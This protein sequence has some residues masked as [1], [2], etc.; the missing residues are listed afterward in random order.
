MRRGS[1]AP[2]NLNAV[3]KSSADPHRHYRAGA[4]AIVFDFFED[5][6]R[7]M[8]NIAGSIS[9]HIYVGDI[10]YVEAEG[11]VVEGDNFHKGGKPG[12]GVVLFDI[13]D[14]PTLGTAVDTVPHIDTVVHL[15]LGKVMPETKIKF[16]AIVIIK[17]MHGVLERVR[18]PGVSGTG[19]RGDQYIG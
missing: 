6:V 8:P 15:P 16:T 2:G 1:L 3:L 18:N 14:I 12:I 5:I 17:A 19:A 4:T 13:V 7:D 10:I 9:A 11:K